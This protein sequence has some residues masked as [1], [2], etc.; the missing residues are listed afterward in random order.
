MGR[1]CKE[2]YG[3]NW[4]KLDKACASV[5]RLTRC[6][7]MQ[8]E[9]NTRDD[10]Y[11]EGIQEKK[12]LNLNAEPV[13]LTDLVKEKQKE[14]KEAKIKVVFNLNSDDTDE[15]IKLGNFVKKYP[16]N[17]NYRIARDIYF[18]IVEKG[19]NPVAVIQSLKQSGFTEN[20]VRNYIYEPMHREHP[21][22]T[23]QEFEYYWN[24]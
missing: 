22:N 1:N 23:G 8:R 20:F 14:I 18:G 24:K 15:R 4:T 12:Y 3:D 21:S 6:F 19:I 9:K 16:D 2:I 5:G 17:E 10:I 13:D 7:N 11:I